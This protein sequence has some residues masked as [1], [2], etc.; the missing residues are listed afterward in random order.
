MEEVTLAGLGGL[1][2]DLAPTDLY[3]LAQALT[4]V[5]PA[6]ATGCLV[7]GSDLIREGQQVIRPD[8]TLAQRLGSD[9]EGDAT[10][11][12]DCQG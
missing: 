4:Q 11:E 9:A 7:F 10:L 12:P 2:T 8:V 1:E 5:D 6:K 3:R